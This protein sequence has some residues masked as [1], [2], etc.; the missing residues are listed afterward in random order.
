MDDRPRLVARSNGGEGMSPEA[1]NRVKNIFE[2]VVAHEGAD[3]AALLAVACEGDEELRSEVERLIAGHEQAGSFLDRPP[4]APFFSGPPGDPVQIGRVLSHYQILEKLGEGGMGTVYRAVHTE[5]RRH[6]AIKVLTPQML[7]DT[8]RNE[9]FLR[10]ARAASAL[11]HPNIGHVYEIGEEAGT[12]FI[13]MEYIEGRTLSSAISDGLLNFATIVKFGMQAADALAE[14]HTHGIVHR[15]IKP[16]N[17]MIGSRGELKVVDFGLAKIVLGPGDE[18][19]DVA[20]T[21]PGMLMGT[22]QY[23]SPEQLLGQNVDHRSDIFS[24]GL[25]LFEMACGRPA[26]CGA[27]PVETIDQILHGTPQAIG[28]SDSGTWNELDRII[29]KCVEKDR[30]RRYQS[31]E[32]LG[33]ELRTLERESGESRRVPV[34]RRVVLATVATS[35]AA[36]AGGVYWSARSN[37]RLGAV[38]DSGLD[39]MSE[40]LAI[41]PFLNVDQDPELE[42]LSDGIPEGLISGL[43]RLPRLRVVTRSAAFSF[44]NR[45]QDT[46]SIRRYLRVHAAL[47]GRIARTN[48]T[49]TVRTFLVDVGSDEQIWEST[50]DQAVS[51]VLK[52]QE[53]IAREVPRRLRIPLSPEDNKQLAKFFAGDPAANQFYLEGRHLLYKS[54]IPEWNQAVE[55]FEKAIHIQPTYALAHAGLAEGYYQLADL[56]LPRADAMRRARAEAE[57]ALEID[58]TLAEA[59]VSLGLI[60]HFHDWDY[61]GAENEFRRAI[62]LQPNS[63]TAYLWY[64]WTLVST[65]RHAEGLQ[66]TLRARELDPLNRSI[67]L[68]LAQQSYYSRQFDDALTQLKNILSADPSFWPAYRWLV[69]IYAGKKAYA[70]GFAAYEKGKPLESDPDAA[71]SSLGYLYAV[72]GRRREAEN[73]IQRLVNASKTRYVSPYYTALIFAGLGDKDQAFECLNKGYMARCAEM[74]Y[75]RVDPLLDNLRSDPRFPKLLQAV[76]LA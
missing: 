62:A 60:R 75:L 48:K 25:V 58:S 42:Y 65:G 52:L 27:T 9:R 74:V 68:A 40:S 36:I 20:L 6:V 61:A 57:K 64:G 53:E 7:P 33:Q 47:L 70:D 45:P 28:R 44:R 54:T 56:S 2:D 12:R 19:S 1:W 17:M 59:H 34:S 39:H 4:S 63:S 49:I 29:R 11:N 16:S 50:Y 21:R 15:D 71:A 14:A 32:R 10:E 31:A 3:R 76:G 67:D 51:E 66:K 46:G 38:Q 35:F 72:S 55:L 24:L 37:R 22:V 30:E 26:F 73:Q 8:E 5:L 43:S 69:L 13:A 18:V 41:L 23:M